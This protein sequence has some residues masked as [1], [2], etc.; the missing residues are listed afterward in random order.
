MI[1]NE[2]NDV[3]RTRQKISADHDHDINKLVAHYQKIEVELR[4]SG[5]FRFAADV[6]DRHTESEEHVTKR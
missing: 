3:R 2:I 4:A 6:R 5:R 1:D